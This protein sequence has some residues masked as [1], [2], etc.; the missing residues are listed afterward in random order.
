MVAVSI[1]LCSAAGGAGIFSIVYLGFGTV[2][3]SIS[4]PSIAQPPYGQFYALIMVPLAGLFG[5]LLGASISSWLL[6]HRQ[7]ASFLSILAG[8]V[9]L[10]AV[11]G[12]WVQQALKYGVWPCDVFMY[13]PLILSAVALVA[14]GIRWVF[15]PPMNR[16]LDGWTT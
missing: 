4:Q 10:A 12:L 15:A 16:K 11:V 1:T 9:Y 5:G 3:E 7:F 13:P 8:S 6:G 14:I 2:F